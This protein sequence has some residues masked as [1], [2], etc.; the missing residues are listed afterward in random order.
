MSTWRE[1]RKQELREE[2]YESAL[3]LFRKDGYEATTVQQIT[4]GLGIAKG[5]F[6]NHFPSKEHIVVR[7]YNGITDITIS[8]AKKRDKAS[9][10]EAVCELFGDMARR[11]TLEPELLVAKF[12]YCTNPELMEAEKRQVQAIRDLIVGYCEAGIH[13]GEMDSGL[14]IHTLC[15]VLI[16]TL[17]GTSRSWVYANPSFDFSRVIRQRVTF[18]F[19]AVTP[20][21]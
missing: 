20:E 18:V 19:Q 15:E 5:T 11:A 7:W 8:A 21:S 10:C 6:F 12:R 3:E 14:D 9:A 2:I 1:K 16:A 4:E 17:S 13:R